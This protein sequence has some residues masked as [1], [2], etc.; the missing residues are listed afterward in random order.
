M[1]GYEPDLEILEALLAKAYEKLRIARISFDNKFYND[2]ASRAYYAAFHAV[3]A[4]LA[5]HGFTFSSHGKVLGSFNRELINKGLF[6]VDTAQKLQRLFRDR[7]I[8]DYYIDKEIS[9]EAAER[10]TADAEEIVRLCREY[11]EKSLGQ[12]LSSEE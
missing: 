9:H 7:Q 6:P 8:G 3:T 1:S 11:L 2:A 12:N 4:V 10:D 5:F